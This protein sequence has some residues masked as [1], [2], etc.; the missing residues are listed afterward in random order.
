MKAARARLDNLTRRCI[1]YD[2]SRCRR[3]LIRL[4]PSSK[5]APKTVQFLER[6][7]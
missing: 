2:E 1:L 4:K 6:F 7:R 5:M 3:R